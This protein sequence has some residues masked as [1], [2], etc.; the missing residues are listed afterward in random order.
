MNLDGYVACICEGSAEQ[1]IMELLLDSN[2]LVFKTEQLLEEEIIRC[3]SA[4]NFEKTYLRKGFKEKITVLR[5][6]D[7]RRENFNLS[8]AYV[9]KIDVINIITAPEIEMLIIFH[10]DKYN[11][12]NKSKMKPSEFCKMK[13]KFSKVKNYDF[14]KDYFSDI[15]K[16]LKSIYEYRRVSN[17]Q[18][19]EQTL[20]DLL[21]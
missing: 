8:K 21:K 19:G 9:D 16:L 2:E 11:E 5:I 10:E 20:F 3:R 13:L 4:K 12:F 17:I 14:V 6:L 15:D 18:K 7:S 1:A